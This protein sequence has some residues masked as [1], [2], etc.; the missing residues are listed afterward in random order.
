MQKPFYYFLLLSFVIVFGCSEDKVALKKVAKG[1]KRYGGEITY[2]SPEMVDQFFPLSCLS[3]YEQRAISPI[4][5]TLIQFN[6]ETNELSGNLISSYTISKDLKTIDLN[7]N[8][9][10]YFH[11]DICFGGKAEELTATDIKFTLDF[12]CTPHKLNQQSELL[13]TKIDGAK[14]LYDSFEENISKGVSGIKILSR[15]SL[16]IELVNP[17]PTFLKVLTHQSMS[18]FSKK[19][20]EYYKEKIKEHPV[21][22]GPFKLFSSNEKER[23]YIRNDKYWGKDKYGNQ[24]PFIDKIKVK[25]QKEK[26]AFSSF[27]TQKTD[28]LLS[29]PANEINSLFGTLDEAKDG[30]NILH[31]LQYR[32]G[33]KMNY[34]A[35]DCSS[36]PFNDLHLRKAVFHAVNR[37][38][39]CSSFLFGESNPALNGILPQGVYFQS[40]HSPARAYNLQLAKHHLRRS[41]YRGDSLVFYANVEEGSSEMDWCNYLV[42]DLNK[43]L[44]LKIRLMTG[45]YQGKLNSIQAGESKMWMGAYVPDY[46]DAESYLIPYSSNNFGNSVRSFGNYKSDEFDAVFEKS[47]IEVDDKL[48]N[49]LFNECISVMNNEA[50]VVPVY[51]ENLLVVYNLNLRDANMNSFGIIDFS[52]AYIKP[53]K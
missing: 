28:L 37:E 44:G 23:V 19:A 15:Y 17:S 43:K 12:A 51:F 24:L 4:F 27:T 29:V 46:P 48:R 40:N 6:E 22:T 34:I 53:I 26:K 36:A 8:K 11:D 3:M 38:N 45:T 16:R 39:I 32:K 13:I 21:G 52:E 2:E 5:E 7:L 49:D 47:A 20:Y 41:N 31:K 10:I 33:L 35:F 50:P 18:V 14:V 30:K 9:G 25:Q 1:E 42:N